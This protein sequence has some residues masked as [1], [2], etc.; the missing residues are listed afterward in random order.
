MKKIEIYEVDKD[1]NIIGFVNVDRR[2]ENEIF[3]DVLEALKAQ[4]DITIGEKT[5]RALDDC[6]TCSYHGETFE[7]VNDIDYGVLIHI[8]DASVKNELIKLLERA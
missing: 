4:K 3:D 5:N 8:Q 7:V 6:C 1:P 2:P